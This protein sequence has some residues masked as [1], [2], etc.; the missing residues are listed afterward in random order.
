MEATSRVAQ[1]KLKEILGLE[2]GVSHFKST[3]IGNYL[4]FISGIMLHLLNQNLKILLQQTS[5]FFY[6]NIKLN[7]NFLTTF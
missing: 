3:G 2:A 5:S 6:Y 7:Q 1:Q 4:Y